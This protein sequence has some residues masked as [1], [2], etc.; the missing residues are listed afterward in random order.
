[1][2]HV[3]AKVNVDVMVC[4]LSA[5]AYN[6]LKSVERSLRPRRKPSGGEFE[7][8]VEVESAK[9][10]MRME[11]ARSAELENQALAW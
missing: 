2:I 6:T 7:L 5:S 8:S 11:L 1:M 3:L 10:H 9:Q 4:K